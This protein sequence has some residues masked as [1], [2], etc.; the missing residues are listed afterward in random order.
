MNAASNLT[1]KPES[2]DRRL[3]TPALNVSLQKLHYINDC[4]FFSYTLTFIFH[5]RHLKVLE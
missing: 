5:Y 4:T 2:T 1:E 3:E